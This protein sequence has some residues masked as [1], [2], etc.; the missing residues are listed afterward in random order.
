MAVLSSG[1]GQPD[2]L[3]AGTRARNLLTDVGIW[4][5]WTAERR[6]GQDGE[7]SVWNVGG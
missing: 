6:G 3:S 5:I 4:D 1:D 7:V 2:V